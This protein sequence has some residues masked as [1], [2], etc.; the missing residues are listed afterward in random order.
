MAATSA[1]T[2]FSFTGSNDTLNL[3]G[4]GDTVT[5]TGSNDLINVSGFNDVVTVTGA[6][7]TGSLTSANT[8]FSFTGSN[9]IIN[10]VGSG[11]TVTA[12]GNINTINVIGSN[13][14]ITVNGNNN[15]AVLGTGTAQLI[16]TGST[17]ATTLGAGNDNVSYANGTNVV[18]ATLGTGATLHTGDILNGGVGSDTV[19]LSGAGAFDFNTI[20]FKGFETVNMGANEALSF[21][22]SN[23]AINASIGGSDSFHFHSNL[24]SNNTINNFIGGS[25]ANRDA[26][27]LD[28]SVLA[29]HQSAAQWEN[30]NVS[31]SN[32]N[33]I[34]HDGTDI[35][36]VHNANV[37]AVIHDLFF[38]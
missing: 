31:S 10:V 23:L 6:T 16:F 19:N 20:I 5:A 18:S 1:N 21:N 2:H 35:I 14:A 7:D 30:T 9:D 15:A 22:G 28:A 38:V 11:D 17:N 36:T 8:T 27:Y 13:D 26:I 24:V 29:A 12:M 37:A 32:G 25:A 4:S 33:V 34:I 3:V